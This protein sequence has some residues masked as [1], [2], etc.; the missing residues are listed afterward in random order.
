MTRR[1]LFTNTSVG[2]FTEL[3]EGLLIKDVD[4]EQVVRVV[5]LEGWT[6]YIDDGGHL[7]EREHTI[8]YL[9][10]SDFHTLAEGAM[11]FLGP[12]LAEDQA[13]D[14]QVDGE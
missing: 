14:G 6:E 12:I 5:G 4:G 11:A 8:V 13:D 3:A 1:L 2:L 7:A 10:A 9:R